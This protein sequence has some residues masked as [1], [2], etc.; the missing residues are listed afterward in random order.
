MQSV[1]DVKDDVSTLKM[2]AI[3]L[4]VTIK[5][6][7]LERDYLGPNPV[8]KP[9]DQ[10]PSGHPSVSPTP[11]SSGEMEATTSFSKATTKSP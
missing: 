6:P 4:D 10:G 7:G 11:S 1:G 2:K 9:A 8:I 5:G 3:L